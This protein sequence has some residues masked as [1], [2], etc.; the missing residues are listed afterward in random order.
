MTTGDSRTLMSKNY[1]LQGETF[2]FG[3]N[4]NQIKTVRN[5]V[6]SI[7][8]YL[9]KKSLV[10]KKGSNKRFWKRLLIK[11]DELLCLYAQIQG[12]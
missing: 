2:N 12:L 9:P 8:K 4:D 7:H 11:I 5:V 3:P 6:R 1:N 10:I